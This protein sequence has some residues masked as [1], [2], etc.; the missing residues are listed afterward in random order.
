MLCGVCSGLE[1]EEFDNTFW[2]RRRVEL[3]DSDVV[4]KSLDRQKACVIKL[5]SIVACLFTNN[6]AM[7]PA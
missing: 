1:K 4:L 3:G 5:W 7:A 6:L 2:T